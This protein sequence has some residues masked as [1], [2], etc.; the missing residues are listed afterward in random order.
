MK[1][2]NLQPKAVAAARTTGAKKIKTFTEFINESV[3]INPTENKPKY[4]GRYFVILKEGNT[5]FTKAKRVLENKANFKIAS[6]NDF[7]NETFTQSKIADADAYIYNDL[8]IALIGGEDDQI[9]SVQSNSDDEYIVV[10][11]LIVEIPRDFQAQLTIPSTWGVKATKAD[12]SGYTGKGVKVAVLDTGFDTAH[13]DFANRTVVTQ[14]FTG[15]PF[16]DMHGHGTHC[17][18]SACGNIDLNGIRYGVAID[19]LIYSG[20]V[21]DNSGSGAQ[22]WILDGMDWAVKQGCKVISMS[23]G[24]P[25][26]VGQTYNLAYERQAKM[27]LSKG[28]I[29]V[30]AA[31]NESRRAWNV[32]NPVGSPADCPSV[33]AVAAVDENMNVADFSNRSINPTGKIGI[34][35]PGVAVY[36]AWPLPKRYNTISGTSMA[37]PHVA[38]I[39][40]LL[41]EKYPN[42]L[43]EQILVELFKL[44]KQL[45][46]QNVDVGAGLVTAPVVAHTFV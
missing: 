41:W 9:K 34:A 1:K 43:P 8:G 40:A 24:S 6:S 18:G 3:E 5:N 2:P 17:I 38:G 36:S 37:T 7:I 13:P 19:S 11:E 15:E 39:I 44:A 21:L 14:S 42:Y 27:A 32:I 20:K 4:T 23:L 28:C 29:V 31:G 46:A 10:P 22:S 12:E 16:A 33:L 25:V 35:G 45:T 30:A 26:Y